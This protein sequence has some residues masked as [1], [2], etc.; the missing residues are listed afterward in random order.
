MSTDKKDEKQIILTF[1]FKYDDLKKY[2]S[3]AE[4]LI[5]EVPLFC[6]ANDILDGSRPE[7]GG[8]IGQPNVMMSKDAITEFMAHAS[9]HLNAKI[10][11]ANVQSLFSATNIIVKNSKD[12]ASGKLEAIKDSAK[13]MSDMADGLIEESLVMGAALGTE[14]C[15]LVTTVGEEDIKKILGDA[16]E[17]MDG[18][19][20][21]IV[22]IQTGVDHTPISR[23][24][25]EQY[26]KT[27]GNFRRSQGELLKEFAKKSFEAMLKEE[28]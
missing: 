15:A 9:A 17:I 25:A 21:A 4:F 27:M 1:P 5:E 12:F 2:T 28:D 7:A 11:K 13:A 14:V 6:T 22:V 8:F 23:K 3:L 16:P 20:S 10:A 19:D 26:V 18:Y 24:H